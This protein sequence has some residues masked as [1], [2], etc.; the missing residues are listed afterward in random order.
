MQHC[1]VSRS[2]N[3]RIS[4]ASSH[5]ISGGT[6]VEMLL[7]IGLEMTPAARIIRAV[8]LLPA[9]SR[10]QEKLLVALRS[11]QPARFHAQNLEPKFARTFR[12]AVDRLLMQRRVAHNPALSH[13]ALFQFELWLD[14]NQEIRARRRD[15]RNRRQ[16]LR[17]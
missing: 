6:T 17:R 4:R 12:H 13:L 14:Q 10:V 8:I 11:R 2:T 15:R 1:C 5:S 16:H 9:A 7:L 3:T